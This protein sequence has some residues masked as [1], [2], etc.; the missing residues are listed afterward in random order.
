MII[1][2]SIIFLLLIF[3]IFLS[4]NLYF[5][6]DELKL[7]YLIKIFNIKLIRGYA[8]VIKE[9]I[10]IHLTKNR[11]ILLPFNKVFTLKDKVKPL[12]DYHVIKSSLVIEIGN[13]ENNFLP[14]SSAYVLNFINNLISFHLY[15][16]KPYVKT[17]T[18]CNVF[19]DKDIFTIKLDSTIV[20]NLMMIIISLIKICTE[21]MYYAIAK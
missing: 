8:E 14:L 4:I 12:K 1:L 15:Q 10:I 7:F 18:I 13:I 20:F 2:F 3:P 16:R 17:N 19:I 21:K 9:G 6:K 5:N 11:A